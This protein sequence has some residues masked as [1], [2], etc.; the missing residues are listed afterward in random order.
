MSIKAT[1]RGKEWW[2]T[3]FDDGYVIITDDSG[4]IISMHREQ[5]N[6]DEVIKFYLADGWRVSGAT[7]PKRKEEL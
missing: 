7:A 2:G 1:L 5:M 3:V 6:A 4:R